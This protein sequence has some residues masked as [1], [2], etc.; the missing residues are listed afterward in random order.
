MAIYVDYNVANDRRKQTRTRSQNTD[1]LGGEVV[2]SIPKRHHFVPQ[3]Y[4]KQ[5]SIDEQIFAFDKP[6]RRS[7]HTNIANVAV[8]RF[9]YGFPNEMVDRLRDQFPDH[10]GQTLKGVDFRIV[11]EQWFNPLEDTIGILIPHLR[12]RIQNQRHFRLKGSEQE[13]LAGF[14]T[15]QWL[16]TKALRANI[17]D[18]VGAATAHWLYQRSP[19]HLRMSSPPKVALGPDYE[20]IFHAK[21]ILD[22]QVRNEI[23]HLLLSRERVWLFMRNS[24]NVPFYTSD[25]PITVYSHNDVAIGLASPGVEIAVPLA[26]DLI[27]IIADVKHMNPGGR[28]RNRKTHKRATDMDDKEDVK[29]YNRLQVVS[30]YR[31]VFCQTDDFKFASKVCR[32]NP[33]ICDMNRQRISLNKAG[34]GDT[35]MYPGNPNQ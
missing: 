23:I 29:F 13:E 17:V 8:E 18:V 7:F 35:T 22:P 9:F 4:L 21:M 10:I 14:V 11:V 26:P 31:Q 2:H 25:A 30:S 15:I 28:R 16:R 20:S 33:E 3:A 19:A 12:D 6:S 34:F 24:T 5:F 32:D 1:P 27:L